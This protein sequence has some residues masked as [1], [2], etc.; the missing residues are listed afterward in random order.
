MAAVAGAALLVGCTAGA[1]ESPEPEDERTVVSASPSMSP[2]VSVSPSASP[3]PS[4]TTFESYPGELPTEDAE[5][6]AIIAGWQEY[7]RVVAKFSAD[8]LGFSDF[9]ETQNVTTG[10]EKVVVLDMLAGYREE[11]LKVIGRFAF[12]DVVVSPVEAN[13][14]G[15]RE[16]SLSYCVDR[17]NM[18]VLTYDGV[19]RDTS[20]LTAT[21]PETATLV[22]GADAVWRVSKI[23][24]SQDREC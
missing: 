8:P 6:A 4:P 17:S 9:T 1:V 11:Q 15:L 21:F 12:D 3:S 22:E 19:A 5:S 13:A 18:Q 7:Q 23:R 16:V 20:E 10:N 2:S 14:E 24:N